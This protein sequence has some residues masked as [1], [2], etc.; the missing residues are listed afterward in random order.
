MNSMRAIKLVKKG[1]F[2][3]GVF[4]T[5]DEKAKVVIDSAQAD[6]LLAL[7]ITRS[8]PLR[9]VDARIFNREVFESIL[10]EK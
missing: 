4:E 8:S 9:V 7:T 2:R 6:Q 3:E 10:S 1:A 5:I